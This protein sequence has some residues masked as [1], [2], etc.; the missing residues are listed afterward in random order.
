MSCSTSE[1]KAKRR[2]RSLTTR[3]RNGYVGRTPW[4]G[5]ILGLYRSPAAPSA[6]VPVGGS[7]G[8]REF[9]SA[10][11]PDYSN[12]TPIYWPDE[13]LAYIYDPDRCHSIRIR[14]PD[15]GRLV[16]KRCRRRE[17][18]GLVRTEPT[19][20]RNRLAA[21]E[22]RQSP[23]LRM[24]RHLGTASQVQSLHKPERHCRRDRNPSPGRNRRNLGQ[25]RSVGSTRDRHTSEPR[26]P[27]LALNS[28]ASSSRDRSTPTS[29]SVESRT[30]DPSKPGRRTTS[31]S[32]CDSLGEPNN[33]TTVPSSLV[34]HSSVPR[35]STGTSADAGSRRSPR[36]PTNS[37]SPRPSARPLASPTSS[38]HGPPQSLRSNTHQRGVESR[39]QRVEALATA[40]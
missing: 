5:L 17:Q 24:S 1:L 33:R 18:V 8:R 40:N 26:N 21:L 28:R 30:S 31:S 13:A 3:P 37:N 38:S 12:G 29:S 15:N 7:S 16:T 32:E 35:N 23:G 20:E 36:N 4:S 14:L 25:T 11:R 9:R 34:P 19:W 10:E 39:L 27:T 22:L 2:S 6:G